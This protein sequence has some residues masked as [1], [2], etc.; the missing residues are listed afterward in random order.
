MRVS[1]LVLTA[2]RW[3]RA[4][5]SSRSS[6]TTFARL[7]LLFLLRPTLHIHSLILSY[8]ILSYPDLHIH[9]P[10]FFIFLQKQLD[11]LATS[12]KT[13]GTTI[14]SYEGGQSSL[15][16][17]NAIW[18]PTNLLSSS[19]SFD[20]TFARLLFFISLSPTL[21]IHSLILSF[22]LSYLTHYFT[23]L[24]SWSLSFLQMH[25]FILWQQAELGNSYLLV[26]RR[27]VFLCQLEGNL[28]P[29]QL[30]RELLDCLLD[31]D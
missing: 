31:G 19:R 13:R 8:L 7:L 22:S 11:Y 17:L 6:N 5:S 23:F 29:D 2:L 30:V 28:S 9:S 10:T 14:Y 27:L 18:V 16:N 12:T 21:H 25:W 24:I 4:V 15:A 20:T 26:W 3:R 1:D